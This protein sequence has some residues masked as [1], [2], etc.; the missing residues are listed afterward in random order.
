[1]TF[2]TSREDTYQTSLSPTQAYGVGSQFIISGSCPAGNAALQGAIL[3]YP[4]GLNITNPGYPAAPLNPGAT[5]NLASPGV[6]APRA[7][8]LYGQN[9]TIVPFTSTSNGT[10]TA[11]IPLDATGAIFVVLTTANAGEGVNNAK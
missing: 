1:M 8:F 10:G 2:L 7:A 11:T 5:L 3:A 4:P 6:S 9:T